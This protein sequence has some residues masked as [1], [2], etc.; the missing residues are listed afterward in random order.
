MIDV[1]KCKVQSETKQ[2]IWGW[3]M[4]TGPTKHPVNDELC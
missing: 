4:K 1:C 3:Q 2:Y